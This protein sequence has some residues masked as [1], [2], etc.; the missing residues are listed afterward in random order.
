LPQPPDQDP[1]SARERQTASGMATEP[2]GNATL[3]AKRTQLR[4]RVT[5]A[6]VRGLAEA[7]EQPL[8]PGLYLVATPI[9]NL[10]DMTLRALAVLSEA[11]IVYCED[12]RHSLKLTQH[13][14]ITTHLEAYHEHNAH[15]MRPRILSA[16]AKGA[17]VALI[18]DAGTP[19]VSDPGYKLVRSALDAGHQVSAIPGA[20][21]A[22]A[23]LTISGLPADTFLFAGFLPPKTAARQTRLAALAEVPATLIVFEAP[24]RVADCLS[25]IA[26]VLGP[27]PVALARELTKL[28]ET[29]HF[30]NAATLAAAMALE[31][32]RGE[33]VLLI[34]PPLAA[35]AVDDAGILAALTPLLATLPTGAAAKSVANRLGVARNRVY[36]L[37]LTLKRPEAT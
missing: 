8:A 32:T 1:A 24:G 17:R 29:V 36:D 25:D 22:L 21:A 6:A 23:A 20:S 19:L 3:R 9:G 10:A 4:E 26:A 2:A 35:S 30:G 33:C 5:A 31:A 27:R 37:A 28:N 15:V 34:G 7:F 18:S 12:T 13:Y 11:D 16:L 14:A